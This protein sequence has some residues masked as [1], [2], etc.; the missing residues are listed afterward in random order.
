MSVFHGGVGRLALILSG[1]VLLTACATPEELAA[2][3]QEQA[4]VEAARTAAEERIAEALANGECRYRQ[5]TGARTARV[6]QCDPGVLRPGDPEETERALQD[7]QDAGR[8]CRGSG[9]C[10]SG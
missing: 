2:Y 8:T 10:D 1:A 4:D 5:Q 9:A 7:W 3:E 6:L